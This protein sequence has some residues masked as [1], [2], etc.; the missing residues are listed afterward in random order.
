MDGF[1]R[2]GISASPGIFPYGRSFEGIVRFELGGEDSEDRYTL[3]SNNFHS[4][5]ILH[6]IFLDIDKSTGQIVVRY[7]HALMRDLDI[8]DGVITPFGIMIK[9]NRSDLWMWL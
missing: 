3:Q 9:F 5:R 7:W 6:K 4:E 8:M 2:D 1:A